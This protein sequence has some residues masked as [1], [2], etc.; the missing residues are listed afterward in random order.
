LADI[1]KL[2]ALI[3]LQSKQFDQMMK[4]T[5]KN[6]DKGF[7]K[8]KKSSDLF[9]KSLKALPA[10]IGGIAVGAAMRS[11]V[12]KFKQQEMAVR[13][14][15]VA[16][17]QQGGAWDKLGKTV[18]ELASELQEK[19][20][21]GDEAT[22]QAMAKAINTGADYTEVIRNASLAHDIAAATGRDLEMV[23]ELIGRAIQGDVTMLQRYVPAIKQLNAEQR[24]WLNVRELLV[25]TFGGQ[26]AKLAQTE[27]KQLEALVN[28]WGDLLEKGGEMVLKKTGP[29][30]KTL[31]SL[32]SD[33]NAELDKKN[34]LAPT[35][36]IDKS[37]KK[38]I[39]Y[40]KEW[41][42]LE[43]ERN[44]IDLERS[45]YHKLG[46]SPGVFSDN[47]LTK[48]NEEISAVIKSYTAAKKEYEAKKLLYDIDQDRLKVSKDTV[49]VNKEVAESINLTSLFL[50]ELIKTTQKSQKGGAIES[51]FGLEGATLAFGKMNG[52]IQQVTNSLK[53]ME[54]MGVNTAHA[55]AGAFGSWAYDTKQNIGDVAEQF[56]KQMA[57]M[58]TQAAVLA[59]ISY[60]LD[61]SG[62]GWMMRIGSMLTNANG[63][64]FNDGRVQQ[65]AQG[66]VIHGP[67]VFPMR[68]GMGLMGENGPEAIV[69]LR[70]GPDGKL[71]VEAGGSGELN[72]IFNI[73]VGNEEVRAAIVR[74]DDFDSE[75]GIK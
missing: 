55:I 63:N 48:K 16:I 74:M 47:Q 4:R 31:T 2:T 42:K 45:K 70:R 22:L 8:M 65:F 24:D 64:A 1:G 23:Y 46:K 54:D 36:E 60:A 9:S 10:L 53:W 6:T 66:G 18:L 44:L 51:A 34:D 25:N 26:A 17:E 21:F 61:A 43:G 35:P 20:V 19:N 56:A 71:G 28:Q 5:A 69:P 29:A 33:Y 37:Y 73:Y 27:T 72:P 59:A 13:S 15:Q 52:E 38:I 32:V 58:I 67:T 62:V 41:L 68:N 40:E 11:M 75:R 50:S 57:A 39:K 30:V 7:K 12:D 3:E 14:V 49:I